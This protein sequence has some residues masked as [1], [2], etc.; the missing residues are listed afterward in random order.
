MGSSSD[1]SHPEQAVGDRRNF[2][3][4][5]LAG[6][7][8]FILVLSPFLSGLLVFLDPLRRKSKSTGFLRVA[9]LDSVPAD[10]MARRFPVIAERTDAW[11]RYLNEPIGAVYLYRTQG[12]EDV[13]A[14]NAICPHAG[15]SVDFNMEAREFRCPCHNSRFTSEGV[16]LDPGASPSPRDLDRLEVDSARLKQGEVWIEFKNFLAVTPEMIER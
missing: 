7:V 16:R 1:H 14:F 12:A 9:V 4:K 5:L 6:V 2:L 8:G 11:N 13:L 15:C 3:K 10:G